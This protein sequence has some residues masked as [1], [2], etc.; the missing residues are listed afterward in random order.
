ML[1]V[2][3][4]GHN[5]NGLLGSIFSDFQPPIKPS[6]LPKYTGDS[7]CALAGTDIVAMDPIDKVNDLSEI[8][9]VKRIYDDDYSISSHC[10]YDSTSQSVDSLVQCPLN[11]VP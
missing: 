9:R 1:S 11:P 5:R 7:S 2:Y 3:R 8:V 10:T 6:T 4:L